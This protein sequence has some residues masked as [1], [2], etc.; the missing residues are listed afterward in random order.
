EGAG[1]DVVAVH[2]LDGCNAHAR[3]GREVHLAEPAEVRDA[4][5]VRGERELA[6]LRPTADEA[7]PARD[8]G[9]EPVRADDEAGV[10]PEGA[11]PVVPCLD[12][13]DAASRIADHV[14]DV[15]AGARI[16]ARAARALEQHGV[17][18]LATQRDRGLDARITVGCGR[19]GGLERVAAGGNDAPA[20]ESRGAGGEHVHE[21]AE[22][23]QHP[24]GL[25]AQAVAARLGP[26]ERAAIEEQHLV[27]RAGEQQRGR[28]AGGPGADDDRVEGRAHRP[29][30][31]RRWKKWRYTRASWS[32]AARASSS[33]SGAVKARSTDSGPSWR[34]RRL[35]RQTVAAR[36]RAP[37]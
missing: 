7:Q 10:Q 6:Q 22:P 32:P 18:E 16:G 21:Q 33:N 34:V 15:D 31:T 9:T 26:G 1:G 3:A 2:L 29:T 14:R 37:K 23:V 36:R 30:S 12:A 13:A 5:H 28:G 35:R 27:P 19:E 11:A 24:R 25:G 17:E 20:A 4:A 8:D